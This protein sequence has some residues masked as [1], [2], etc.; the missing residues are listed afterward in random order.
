MLIDKTLPCLNTSPHLYLRLR[1]KASSPSRNAQLSKLLK[2]HLRVS[3]ELRKASEASRSMPAFRFGSVIKLGNITA[4]PRRFTWYSS[5]AARPDR[6][7]GYP[8]CQWERL[9]CS[10]YTSNPIP[11]LIRLLNS[12]A[13]KYHD[14]EVVVNRYQ[15][16][17]INNVQLNK[18]HF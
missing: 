6:R 7:F 18:S 2:G 9:G 1:C 13:T 14:V 4:H 10:L 15:D 11:R 5:E 16:Q 17:T 3:V 8:V 12:H